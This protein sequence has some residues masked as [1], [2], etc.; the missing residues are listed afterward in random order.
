MDLNS[1]SAR[2][3][4]V[5]V[6]GLSYLDLT[7]AYT[8]VGSGDPVILLHGIPTWSYLYHDV[9]PQLSNHFRIIAPDF[10]GHGH[11]DR[12]DRFDRS[13]RMQTRAILR[14]M[15]K[16]GLEQATIVGHDTGGGVALMMGIEHPD[17]VDRLVL[18]NA[19]AYDSW[20][21]DDMVKLGSPAW[22]NQEPRGKPRGIPH[23]V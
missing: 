22:Q 3:Q 9:I 13:L 7:I 5:V 20:P 2:Q 12:R 19:V 23:R 8:D 6:E 1:F 16:L 17:R 4:Q 14:F 11:S 18:T 21:I 10:L 15:D